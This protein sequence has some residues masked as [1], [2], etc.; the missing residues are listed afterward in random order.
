MADGFDF[1]G[2]VVLV[3]GSSRGIGAGMIEAFGRA[4]ARCVVNYV[5]DAAGRNKADAERLAAGL[6]DAIMLECDVAS[7]ASVAAMMQQVRDRLGGLDILVNNAGILRDRT[8]K[9]MTSDDW[10]TVLK[11]NLTGPFN[12]IRHATATT[13]PLLREGGRVVNISSLSAFAGMF[14]QANYS[15]SKAG[16]VALT[17]VAARE[18]ARQKITINAVAPGVIDTEIL[19]AVPE[20]MKKK[21]LEQIPIGRFGSV[22]DIV[23]AVLFLCSPLASYITGQVIHVNGGMLMP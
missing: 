20:E 2:K 6:N 4:G 16:L 21:Y 9:K 22:D 19:N 23:N 8:I 18:L 10:D 3:T 12:C 7:D 17:K 5:A 1:S 15:A 13:P 14:G 11:V